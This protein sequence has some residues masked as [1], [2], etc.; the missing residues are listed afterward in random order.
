MIDFINLI[1][2][3]VCQSPILQI[4]SS[5]LVFKRTLHISNND[6]TNSQEKLI[7]LKRYLFQVKKI[8][9]LFLLNID[10]KDKKSSFSIHSTDIWLQIMVDFITPV[11]HATNIYWVSFWSMNA[12][13]RNYRLAQIS[14]ESISSPGTSNMTFNGPQKTE[15]LYENIVIT[16]L[17]RLRH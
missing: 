17:G 5:L 15:N 7:M 11:R 13:I 8:I 3:Q 10:C 2:R 4:N 16:S 14:M 1:C 6:P 12:E 9:A